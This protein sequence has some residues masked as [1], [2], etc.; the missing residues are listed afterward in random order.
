MKQLITKMIQEQTRLG[1]N[2]DPLAIVQDKFEYNIKWY[3]HK[4]E[5]DREMRPQNFKEYCD[6][7]GSP[8]SI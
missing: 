5:S 7:N 3:W 6:K 2:G 4:P 8:N 1:G